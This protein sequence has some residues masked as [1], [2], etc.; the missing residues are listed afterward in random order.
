MCELFPYHRDTGLFDEYRR[1]AENGIPARKRDYVLERDDGQ[2]E[3][4]KKVYDI[5]VSP[6]E[7]GVCVT[8]RDVTEE[9]VMW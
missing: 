9:A 8:W 1:V 5:S 4:L 3:S 7:D 6:F 2:G